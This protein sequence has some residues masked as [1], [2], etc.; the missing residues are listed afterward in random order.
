MRLDKFLKITNVIKR[1]TVANEVA[2]DGAIYVNDKP[3]KP[4][5][6]V[7]IGDIIQLKMW[8]YEKVIKVLQLPSK[9]ISKNDIEKYVEVISYKTIDL[10][11]KII[12]DVGEEIF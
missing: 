1:R 7:K 6:T 4:S 5:Y 10:R 12:D 9:Q 2:S 8:N 3:A 11:D